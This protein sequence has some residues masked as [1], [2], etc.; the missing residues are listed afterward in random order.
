MPDAEQQE[1]SANSSV[2][3]GC[4]FA[5]ASLLF[6]L[7]VSLALFAAYL[8][9]LSLPGPNDKMG[10]AIISTVLW[11]ITGGVAVL[12]FKLLRKI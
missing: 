8:S 7:L 3:W 1:R 5:A 10:F 9:S 4:G 2:A 11:V 6:V 12:L